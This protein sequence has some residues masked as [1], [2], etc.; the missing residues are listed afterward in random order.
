MLTLCTTFPKR[1]KNTGN[2]IFVAIGANL[3]GAAGETPLQICER[4]VRAIAALPGISRAMR[5]RWFSSAPVPPSGQPRYI[6][7]V[8]RCHGK[9]APDILLM[10][11]QAIERAEGRT[12]G[13]PNAARTLDLDIIDMDGQCRDAPDPI[14]PHPRAATRAFVLLPL[15]DIAPGWV[16][17]ATGQGIGA[18]IDAL[19]LQDISPTA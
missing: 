16:H 5:S 2:T 14:L 11:L 19:P 15:R 10:A 13:V 1:T 8:L 6:N 17:P 4:A 12:R 9:M 3:P 7:G 18:L